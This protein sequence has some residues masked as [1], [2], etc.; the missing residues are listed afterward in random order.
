MALALGWPVPLDAATG[1]PLYQNNF[2]S[3]AVEDVPED[4][5]ILDGF[6][7]VKQEGDNKVLE[8]PGAPL[9]T[10]G[11]LFGPKALDGVTVSARIH[12]TNTKR[13]YPAFGLGLNGL[14]GHRLMLAP[15]KRQLEL[16]RG[17]TE[18][19]AVD[20]QWEPGTWT[21]FKLQARKVGAGEW[22]VESKIWPEGSKE[23][24]AWTIEHADKE[25]PYEGQASIWGKP[26]SGTP[27]RYDDLAVFSIAP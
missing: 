19:A 26:F 6:F 17:D 2:E 18:V 3:A 16:Y 23:P 9:G 1:K 4:F 8:L 22:R 15:A 14:A 24:E 10:F 21:H 11:I 13:R 7:A 5:L 20:Y 27:I 12:G 25:A